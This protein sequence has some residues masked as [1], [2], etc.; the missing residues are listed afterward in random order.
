MYGRKDHIYSNF[1]FVDSCIWSSGNYSRKHLEYQQV[2][3]F[4][5]VVEIVFDIIT[6]LLGLL[7]GGLIGVLFWLNGRGRDK[8]LALSCVSY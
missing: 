5:E 2:E 6:Q 1:G 4:V 8:L 3:V 7:G